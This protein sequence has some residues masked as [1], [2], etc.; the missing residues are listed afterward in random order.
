[1][2]KAEDF[3]RK[4]NEFIFESDA[5]RIETLNGITWMEFEDGSTLDFTNPMSH[6]KDNND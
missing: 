3:R 4:L 1:M 6:E 5:V 2:N